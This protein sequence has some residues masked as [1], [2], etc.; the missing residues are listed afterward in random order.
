[1]PIS[2]QY[3]H[4][5]FWRPHYASSSECSDEDISV[6]TPEDADELSDEP[7]TNFRSIVNDLDD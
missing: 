2:F 7:L 6:I 3:N 1:M 4:S 5:N